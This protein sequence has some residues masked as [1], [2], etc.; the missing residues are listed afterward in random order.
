MKLSDNAVIIGLFFAIV[1]VY[2]P[3]FKDIQSEP[4]GIVSNAF[5]CSIGMA[6][7]FLIVLAVTSWKRP[8]KK[9]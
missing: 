6:C 8:E 2:Y 1:G 9:E 5:I 4:F 3:V 7:S